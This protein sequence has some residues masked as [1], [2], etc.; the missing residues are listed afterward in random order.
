MNK[1]ILLNGASPIKLNIA[2]VFARLKKPHPRLSPAKK[3]GQAREE[4][5]IKNPTS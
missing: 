2:A 5:A 4:F 3:A 1:D